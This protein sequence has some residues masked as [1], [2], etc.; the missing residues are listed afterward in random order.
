[1]QIMSDTGTDISFSFTDRVCVICRLDYAIST[2]KG[3]RINATQKGIS[4]LTRYS[5]LRADEPLCAFLASN[6]AVVSYHQDCFRTYTSERSFQQQKRHFTPSEE[7]APSKSMRSSDGGFLWKEHCFFCGKSVNLDTRYRCAKD[8]WLVRTLEL[9]SKVLLVC[10][11]RNDSW[12]LQVS[13]RL[14][15]CNDLVA[16]E[17]RYHGKCYR[18]FNNSQP[19]PADTSCSDRPVL[20]ADEKKLQAFETLCQW[21]ET[22]SDLYAVS[23]LH[24]IMQE[25]AGSGA[26]IYSVKHL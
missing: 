8:N 22:S 4:S 3:K 10:R 20:M 21:L 14:E 13:G 17:A 18:Y 26:D 2:D 6:P 5:D 7:P 19:N 1:M 9:R 11:R 12:S 16:E 25:L 24:D 23:E 15:A